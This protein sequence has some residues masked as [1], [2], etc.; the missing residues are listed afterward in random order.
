MIERL[1]GKVEKITLLERVA[2]ALDMCEI[3]IDFDT[4]IIIHE[5]NYL[6]HP[7]YHYWQIHNY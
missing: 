5:Y 6:L 4:M 7:N 3:V 1:Y 2:D